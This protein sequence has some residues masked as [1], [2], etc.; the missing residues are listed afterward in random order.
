MNGTAWL[1]DPHGPLL[2]LSLRVPATTA[3][4]AVP[5]VLLA[6]LLGYCAYTDLFRGNIIP[7][8][9]TGGLFL[10]AVGVVP[11]LYE[12][13]LQHYLVAA[14]LC[15]LMLPLMFSG[16]GG[17]DVK[18]YMGLAVLLG[19][20][21]VI[22]FFASVFLVLA[23]SLPV[24]VRTVQRNRREGIKARRGHRLGGAPAAPGIALGFPAMLVLTGMP[25]WAP[26]SLAAVMA[27]AIVFFSYWDQAAAR[28][29]AEREEARLAAER[30]LAAR[31][32]ALENERQAAMWE[33]YE[34]DLR[35]VEG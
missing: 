15:A 25:L 19:P 24:M 22:V 16:M 26:A 21:F 1:L 5:M 23:Y 34:L 27:L 12:N 6:L 8:G 2:D 13:P 4:L 18:L 33:Q 35:S 30:K 14:V 17:G 3:V 29:E 10:A 28:A 7:N 11:L 31:Q 9:A 32:E 20:A